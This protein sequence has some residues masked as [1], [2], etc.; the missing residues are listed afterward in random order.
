[1]A[2][3][4]Q[5]DESDVI[6]GLEYTQPPE[7]G[8]QSSI[9]SGNGFMTLDTQTPYGATN[10]E[11][12]FNP[13]TWADDSATSNYDNP[14]PEQPSLLKSAWSTLS[15]WFGPKADASG[16]QQQSFAASIVLGAA[17]SVL[18]SMQ[19][20]KRIKADRDLESQRSSNRIAERKAEED[21][22]RGAASAMPVTANRG[23]R[24]VRSGGLLSTAR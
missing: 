11:A 22:V 8:G 19:A 16:R 24:T 3:Y 12:I 10:P 7:A 20:D 23:T 9:E 1:M 4:D 13:Q 5:F 2:D 17:G 21:R 14:E 6:G 18:Q 15:D